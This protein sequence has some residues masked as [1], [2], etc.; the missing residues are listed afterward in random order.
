MPNVRNLGMTIGSTD[1]SF[2]SAGLLPESSLDSECMCSGTPLHLLMFRHTLHATNRVHK[3][4]KNLCLLQPCT[5]PSRAVASTT[6]TTH[7]RGEYRCG[8]SPLRTDRLLSN[9]GYCSRSECKSYISRHEVTSDGERIKSC[10]IKVATS[11]H[12]TL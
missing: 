4:S 11:Q 10:S 1:F 3:H 2:V 9:L 12:H 8:A 6:E 7:G 5:K